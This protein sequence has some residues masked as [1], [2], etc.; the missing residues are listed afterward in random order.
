MNSK[1]IEIPIEKLFLA[2][3]L[4]F[5]LGIIF[6]ISNGNYVEENGVSMPFV[7]YV[8]SFISLILGGIL[9]ML[10]QNKFNNNKDYLKLLEF[11]DKLIIETLIDNNYKLEQNQIVALTG[12]SKVRVSRILKKFENKKVILKKTLGN[13]NLIILKMR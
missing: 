5:T 4:M 2:L 9:F 3:F 6:A 1:N 8:I 11:N 7:V 12:I 10:F 13:T